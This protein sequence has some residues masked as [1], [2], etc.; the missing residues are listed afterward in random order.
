M[1]GKTIRHYT[2]TEK[3]GEGGMGVVYK[4]RDSHLDRDVA[5]K[6]LPAEAVA[7]P[8]RKRRFVQEAKSASAINHPNI[9]HVYDID[10]VDG[11][12]FI[13]MELVDGRTLADAV[14]RRAIPVGEAL[15]Y[16]VQIADALAAAHAEGIVHRDLKPANIMVTQKGLVK[17]LDFGLAKLT[18]PAQDRECATTRME[19]S[20]TEQGALVGTVGYMSPEQAEGKKLD[21]RSDIFSFGSVLYEMVTGRRAFQVESR[22]ATLSAI[23]HQEPAPIQ[24]VPPELEKVIARCLRKDPERR[25]QHMADLKLALQELKEESDSGKLG[26]SAAGPVPRRRLSTPIKVVGIVLVLAAGTGF[27][28][29][30]LRSQ[31]PPAPAPRA[32]T[33]KLTI[34]KPT[35]GTV[36]GEQLMCGTVGSEC[37]ADVPSGQQ[38][39]LRL[40]A[41]PGWTFSQ[42]TGDCP[43]DGEMTMTAAKTCGAT[44]TPASTRFA[45]VTPSESAGPPQPRRKKET[46]EVTPPRA[47]TDA[48]AEKRPPAE[49][50]LEPLPKE[51]QKDYQKRMDAMRAR[52]DNAVS[53]LQ[54]RAYVQAAR[55]LDQIRKVVP[56]GYLELAQRLDAA[57]SGMREDARRSVDAARAAEDR[58]D[59]DDATEAYRRARDLDPSLKVD[60]PL[61]RIADQKLLLGAKKCAEGKMEFSYGNNAAAVAALQEAIKLLPQS[62]PCYATAQEI[63]K[64]LRK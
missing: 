58:G 54:K 25:A 20:A 45:I 64:K 14:R 11:V 32:V 49:G 60:E 8:D 26:R 35:G 9:I 3:L 21:A 10:Q 62:D 57:R 55:E 44:F 53:M 43:P 17:V 22:L 4:A 36:I 51:T 13:A 29:W 33:F 37:S 47:P 34:R 19:L 41:D 42:F 18:E 5:I 28:T 50:G 31:P 7:D 59:F 15:K 38:V 40:Q 1:I 61:Q 52:Y 2:L 30:L 39:T 24:D 12:D 46:T 6:V 16:A 27:A 63:L 48:V 56:S 23:V